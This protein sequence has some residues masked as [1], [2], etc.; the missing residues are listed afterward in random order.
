MA[1]FVLVNVQT[2][3]HIFTDIFLIC[4]HITFHGPSFNN[5]LLITIKLKTKEIFH[6]FIFTSFQC[7]VLSGASSA[8]HKFFHSPC[9][10]YKSDELKKYNIWMGISV[11]TPVLSFL[12]M[13]D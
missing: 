13:V 12:N 10:Y 5:S 9:C 6:Y 7:C 2:A 3:F 11:I 8:L 4:I 1:V